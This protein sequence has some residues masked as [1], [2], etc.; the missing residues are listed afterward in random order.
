MTGPQHV[1]NGRRVS[2]DH[3]SAATDGALVEYEGKITFA[4]RAAER[5]NPPLVGASIELDGRT[6]RVMTV[7]RLRKLGLIKLSLETIAA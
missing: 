1:E 4:Y 2:F 5:A 7:N 3:P 6:F